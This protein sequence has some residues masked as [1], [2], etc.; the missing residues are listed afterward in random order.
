M[1]ENE[2]KI[3]LQAYEQGLSDMAD[4][5]NRHH[6]ILD[7]ERNRA[8]DNQVTTLTLAAYKG[9]VGPLKEIK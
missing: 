6:V 3:A 5:V 8:I 2:K 4:Y 7:P 9:L 1:T